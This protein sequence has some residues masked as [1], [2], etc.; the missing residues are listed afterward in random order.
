MSLNDY[1]IRAVEHENLSR[2]CVSNFYYGIYTVF[3]EFGEVLGYIRL[4]LA[5][6]TFNI[7]HRYI[8]VCVF[9]CLF[10]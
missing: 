5:K 8:N 9:C 3:M 2:I 4:Y 1:L 6:Q 10:H 7:I